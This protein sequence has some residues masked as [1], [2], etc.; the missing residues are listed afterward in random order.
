MEKIDEMNRQEESNG[1]AMDFG[2]FYKLYASCADDF[3]GLACNKRSVT[4]VL[5]VAAIQALY[6]AR[7]PMRSCQLESVLLS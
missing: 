4:I 1:E 3:H 6:W 7:A 5:V 2:Q